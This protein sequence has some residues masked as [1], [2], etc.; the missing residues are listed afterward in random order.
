MPSIFAAYADTAYEV[1]QMGLAVDLTQYLT[2]DDLS[3]FIDSYIEEGRFTENS[4]MKIFPIAKSIEILMLNKTDWDK[5]AQATGADISKLNTIEGITETAKAYY[6]WTDS[7]TSEPNDGKA[8][9]GRDAMANYMLI[10]SMQLGN[11]IF[12]VKD[13][14]P[15]LNFNKEVVR[16]LWDNYY[17]PYI[18]GYFSSSGRF[19]SDDIK[20]GNIISFVGSSSGATFFPNKVI[21]NDIENYDIETVSYTHLDVY[22]RQGLYGLK[23]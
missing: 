1:D 8:F 21:L 6:E 19:R 4:G 5:F 10:G 23:G 18:N 2:Q 11:E 3:K 12:S 15:V 14:A 9:F 7:L 13:G 20:S 16:K 22:K 17:I